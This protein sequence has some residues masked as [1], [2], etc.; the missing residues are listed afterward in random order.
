VIRVDFDERSAVEGNRTVESA[1]A[2]VQF[3]LFDSASDLKETV[4]NLVRTV[5]ETIQSALSDAIS[6]RVVTY[7]SD[8]LEN[9]TLDPERGNFTG[10]ARMRAVTRLSADGD[11]LLCLPEQDGEVDERIWAI[12]SEAVAH[13]Q[14]YRADLIK[15]VLSA[16]TG[17]IPK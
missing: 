15:S 3:G 5:A 13:A 17:L 7:T 1:S 14:A 6:L 10:S 8:S 2:D 9:V 12:H 16:T 11:T 4:A